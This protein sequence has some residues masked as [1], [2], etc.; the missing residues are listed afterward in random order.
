MRAWRKNPIWSSR[1]SFQ[2]LSMTED[3][4]N[5]QATAIVQASMAQELLMNAI[6][7]QEKLEVDDTYYEENID[8][9]VE[10]T[11]ADSRETL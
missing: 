7:E 8:S 9:Y 4:F 10:M 6:A 1:I 5:S 3:D 11:G 2:Y